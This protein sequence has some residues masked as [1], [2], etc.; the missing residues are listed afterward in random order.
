MASGL[1]LIEWVFDVDELRVWNVLDEEPINLDRTRPLVVLL[2][3]VLVRN[4]MFD[5]RDHFGN[6]TEMLR[7]V[8]TEE[9]EDMRILQLLEGLGVHGLRVCILLFEILEVLKGIIEK[10]VTS[11]G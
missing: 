9:E 2:P 3:E 11:L 8:D 1:V 5:F 4:A 6:T 10:F 7:L